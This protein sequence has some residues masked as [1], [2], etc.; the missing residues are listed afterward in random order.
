MVKVYTSQYR[1][2]GP[3]R[4]DITVKSGD[5][6]FAPTWDMV[7][8][9]KRGEITDE[10]YTKMYYDLMRKS[11]RSHRKRWEEVLHMKRVVFVCF[12]KPGAFCHR[13][14]LAEIF[15]KLGAS[16]EGEIPIDG[17]LF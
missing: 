11:Y 4:L 15:V 9:H 16:Y 8:K 10:E 3:N 6:T 7:W 1:Y 5:K 12:C 13:R 14:L 17:G 2:N